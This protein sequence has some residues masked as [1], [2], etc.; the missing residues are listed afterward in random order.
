M[1]RPRG[2][3]T[4]F[5]IAVGVLGALHVGVFAVLLT[6]LDELGAADRARTA[7][8]AGAVGLTGALLFALLFGAYA[9]SSREITRE[10]AAE[11]A[12]E[13]FFALVSHE[14]RT[15]L[16]A[17]LGYVE[18]VLSDDSGLDAEHARHLEAVE[19]NARRLVRLV[20]DLLLA[21]Q[22]TGG[23]LMI[24]L[25][26]VDLEELARDA[27]DL[28]QPRAEASRIALKAE[29]GPRARC[30]GDRDRL[31]QVL[32]NLIANALAFTPSGGKVT[33]RVSGADDGARLEVADTGVGV[34]DGALPHLFDRFY[35]ARTTAPRP[36]PGLGLGLTIVRA[37]ARAHG[38]DVTVDS[39][40]GE[41][42]TFTV[43]LPARAPARLRARHSS[44]AYGAGDGTS[45]DVGGR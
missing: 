42:T 13:E 2:F 45:A 15:P 35:R 3:S 20:G 28:A 39:R 9:R 36:A 17:I 5:V 33:V 40:L 25:G 21:A 23:P 12:K 19:R 26:S 24:E 1:R 18:L 30:V 14:L 34:P 37:I 7:L 29:I 10:R 8:L 41:G 22:L 16:T 11:R 44:A 31:A 4:R 38:G 27:V 43:S 6:T 32:D